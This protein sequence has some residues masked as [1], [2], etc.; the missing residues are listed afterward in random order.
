M[1]SPDRRVCCG[2]TRSL[3]AALVSRRLASGLRQVAVAA[4]Q[5]PT[6]RC[7]APQITWVTEIDQ[8][9][10]ALIIS[11]QM[12]LER[13]AQRDRADRVMRQKAEELR[14]LN[15]TLEERVLTETSDRQRAEAALH[16]AQKMEAIGQLTG[17]V[18]HDFN[19][20]LQ[21]ISGN[22]E[23]LHAR[24]VD[25]EGAAQGNQL[26]KYA[27][28]AMGATERGAV[29]TQRLLAFSRQ[30]PLTPE[31]SDP[32]AARRVLVSEDYSNIFFEKRNERRKKKKKKNDALFYACAGAVSLEALRIFAM[33]AAGEPVQRK[34]PSNRGVCDLRRI[35]G[36]GRSA[37]GV[38]LTRP[39]VMRSN[40]VVYSTRPC[41][42]TRSADDG[43]F[44]SSR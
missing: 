31:V 15:E 42:A 6:G 28:V 38:P 44:C 2:R 25:E 8:I 14:H 10:A 5:V 4:E 34:P 17:G 22:L 13:T 39:I 19:N 3:V 43:T 16:Q 40:C 26:S 30:Q 7:D 33:V 41:G 20:L 18:A 9:A 29:L 12:I 35:A 21:V 32:N 36:R 23:A 24:L 37:S 27:D 11:A 1:G